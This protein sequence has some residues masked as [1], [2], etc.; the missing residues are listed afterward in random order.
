VKLVHVIWRTLLRY[1]QRAYHFL[2]LLLRS[3]CTP[4]N[5]QRE[6]NALY[7]FYVKRQAK[8][9]QT[10]CVCIFPIFDSIQQNVYSSYVIR[11]S[12]SFCSRY[13]IG[14]RDG[15]LLFFLNREAYLIAVL[16][17]KFYSIYS[18][19]KSVFT[20]HRHYTSLFM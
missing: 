18:T 8:Y 7:S 9:L 10:N 14:I 20:D 4:S 2:L 3:F 5:F 17:K 11:Q 19:G 12:F 16:S 1:S 15:E 6:A 13:K